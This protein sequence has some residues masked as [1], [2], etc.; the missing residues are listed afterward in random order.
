MAETVPADR[1]QR[2]GELRSQLQKASYAYYV[3]DAPDLPDEVY[4]QLYRELQDLEQQYT[5]LVTPDSPT[6]RVGER[7][8]SQFTALEHNIPLYSLEN[9]FDI[10]EYRQWE[11][12]W[13][14]QTPDINEAAVVAELKIDGNALALTYEK[15][16]LTRGVTRGDGI[17]GEDITQNV[18]TI[19]SIPLRLQIENPPPRVEVRGE[20]FIPNDVFEQINA[21]RLVKEEA[22]F[23]NPR[24]AAAGTLRQLDSKVV[25]QRRL[26]FFAYTLLLPD[27]PGGL[28]LPQ[29]QEDALNALQTL[30]FKVNPNRQL[31]PTAKDVAQFYDHWDQVRTQLPYLTDGVVVKLN[32]L[33]LQDRLGF[34][35]KFPRWAIA[36]KYPAEEAP[37]ILQDMTV[38]IGRTGAV[39]PVAELAPVQLAGTTVSRAT[40]HNA[41]RIAELN[42]HKGDTVIV[43]KAGEI[44]PEVVRVLS[45]LRPAGAKLCQLPTHCPECSEKLVRPADEAVTRCINPACPAIVRGDLIHW[46][47]RQSL[48]IAGLGEKWV[49]QLLEQKLVRSVADLYGLTVDDLL[50]LERMGQQLA[51]KLVDAIQASKSQPWSRVLFGLGIR[52]V[53]AVNA[54]LLTQ[55]FYTADLLAAA[56][57][58]QIE[59]VYGIGPEIAYS[60]HEWFQGVA[61]QQLIER[62]KAVGVQLEGPPPAATPV[63]LPM[64]G[65]TFVLTGTL[66][67]LSRKE[68]K[69]KI[70]KCGGKVTGSVSSKTSYVVVGVDAGS[71]LTKAEK[72]GIQRLSEEDLLALLQNVAAP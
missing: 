43:R 2:V 32:D 8:A 14:R 46:T 1:R 47:S 54:Q 52:H 33:A 57:P 48:D 67:T 66:P 58:K 72:L 25:A 63:D 61:N 31:C 24:N 7:P 19:R 36:L 17:S 42:L 20:A 22:P 56:D 70:E 35:Q 13:Q 60:V 5:D 39:T 9:A 37:T 49:Q 34:T 11:V 16:V 4:D 12:R 27:G 71:K 26:D 40:L 68:A 50:P 45:D 6:Q 59:S 38:Q 53:G 62:L 30:G 28:P 29:T 23:A 55:E 10:D 44:I 51:Q 18:R 21:A 69:T 15:G 64:A 3:L 65:K 41:D